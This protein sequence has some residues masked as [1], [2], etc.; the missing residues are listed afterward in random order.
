MFTIYKDLFL[1]GWGR[2]I[3]GS[4]VI[5]KGTLERNEFKRI[6][7]IEHLRNLTKRFLHKQE[8]HIIAV[9]PDPKREHAY[10]QKHA[11]NIYTRF[12]DGL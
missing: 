3:N 1:S 11:L 10:K 9:L 7:E 6:T 5:V 12:V 8:R 2:A 4:Y